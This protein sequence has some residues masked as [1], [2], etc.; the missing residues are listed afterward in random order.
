M[1]NAS[2]AKSDW[3]GMTAPNVTNDP[4][5]NVPG[6]KQYPIEQVLYYHEKHLR[7]LMGAVGQLQLDASE[8]SGKASPNV[9]VEAIK[10]LVKTELSTLLI[11][12]VAVLESK[13]QEQGKSAKFDVEAIKESVKTELSAL[14]TAPIEELKSKIQE[15]GKSAKVDVEAIKESV[16]TELST[17]LTALPR[18][19]DKI[20]EQAE[21]IVSLRQEIE[22][23]RKN[24][25][26]NVELVVD[27]A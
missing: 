22:E 20:H 27:E 5:L 6:I 9:D 12:P 3:G 23:L 2:M 7:N 8:N 21:T 11:A 13:I 1:P 10:E 24:L 18:I 25:E 15:Q 17:L 19:N 4:R 14:L 26:E 16:K